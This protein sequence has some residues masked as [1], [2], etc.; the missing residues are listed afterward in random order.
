MNIYKSATSSIRA[1]TPSIAVFL[2]ANAEWPLSVPSCVNEA[3]GWGDSHAPS[4]P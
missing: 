1:A 2:S 4:N 3:M